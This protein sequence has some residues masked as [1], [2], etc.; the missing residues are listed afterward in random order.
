MVQSK[1]LERRGKKAAFALPSVA[2]LPPFACFTRLQAQCKGQR[3]E[4]C[5]LCKRLEGPMRKLP[6]FSLLAFT[7]LPAEGVG[8]DPSFNV[9]KTVYHSGV[10]STI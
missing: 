7:A 6:G 3:S 4:R 2:D 5:V 1:R 9:M 8:V 10:F